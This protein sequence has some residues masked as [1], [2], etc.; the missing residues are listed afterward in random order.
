LLK[1][2]NF[3]KKI[4]KFGEN[5]EN[6]ENMKKFYDTIAE[7]YDFIFSLSEV[8]KNFFQKYIDKIK[9]QSILRIDNNI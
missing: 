4:L 7:K 1:N 5:M 9:N 2:K 3:I 8:Q 6:K